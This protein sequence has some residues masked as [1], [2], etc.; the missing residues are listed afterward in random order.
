MKKS[1]QISERGRVF[2]GMVISDKM[3]NTVTVEWDRKKLVPKYERYE[4]R[5]T[6][7]KAH[8]PNNINA[9]EGD[10]VRI[11]ETRPISK[12][13]NFIVKEIIKKKELLVKK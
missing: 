5:R 2:E 10:V 7:V 9:K 3:K 4:K 11:I 13:K 6:K 1:K 8:N 12:T